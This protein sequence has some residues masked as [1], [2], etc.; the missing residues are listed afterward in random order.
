MRTR[1]LSVLGLLAIA[2]AGYSSD[3]DA[4]VHLIRLPVVE[5]TDIRFTHLSSPTDSSPGRV[6]HILQDDQGFIWLGTRD[7]LKRYDGYH[8]RE[9]RHD[10]TDPGSLSG[11]FIWALFKDRSGKL[12]VGSDSFL[13]RYD[14]ATDRF[15]R[16][17][18]DPGTAS[19]FKGP[20]YNVSQ[21]R[22]GIIWLS[23][24][25][26]LNRLDPATGQTVRYQ[27]EPNDPSSLSSNLI[28]STLEEKDGTFWVATTDGLDV[29]DRKTGKVTRHF[30]LLGQ[31]EPGR[32]S[33]FEDH[34]G[35]LW[36]IFSSGN[37]I[38]AVDRSANKIYQYS[39]NGQ[40]AHSGLEQL[41][42]IDSIFEDADGTLWLGTHGSGL[43]KL[44]KDR[45]EFVR[46]RNN[47]NDPTSLSADQVVAL[48][49]DRE[50]NMWAGT[51]EGGANRFS[52]KASPFRTYRHQPGN[53]NS[54]DGDIAQSVFEDSRGDLWVATQAA[55]N[56]MDRK[57]GRFIRYLNSGAPGSISNHSVMSI[58]EDRSGTLWFGT[59]GGGLNRLDEATGRFKAYRHNPADPQS[60]SQDIVTSLLVDRDGRLW[61][62]TVN[63][64]NAF[65]PATQRFRVYRAS[66]DGLNQYQVI[67]QD[68][69]GTLWLGT[70]TT[71]LQS[72]EPSTGRFT[73]YRYIPGSAG[74]LSND[75]VNAIYVDHFGIVWVGT[76]SGL[77]RFDPATHTFTAYNERDGLANNNVAGILQD[78]RGNLWL[79]TS[80]GLSRFDP[81]TK[82][83]TNYYVSDGLLKNEF[84]GLH[85]GWKSRSGEMLFN[86]HGGVVSFF[87]EKV[88]GN[89]YI[90]PVVFTDF[91]LFGKPVPIGNGS[92]LRRSIS[93]T[94]SLA[95][96][97]TQNVFSVEFSALSYTSPERNLYRYRLEGLETEW[98]DATGD[99]RLA[100]YTTLPPGD[101]TFRVQG[102]NNRGIW[103]E[104]GATLRIRVLP[105]WW[106]AWWFRV[107]VAVVVFGLLFGG[108]RWRVRDLQE[109]ERRFR[110]LAEHSPD[111]IVRFGRDLR[112]EYTNPAVSES[113]GLP[114]EKLL[115]M[116]SREMG[117]PRDQVGP[118]EAALRQV[119]QT[120]QPLVQ[121]F[122]FFLGQQGTRHFETRMVP[123]LEVD[124]SVR[125]VLAIS[126]DFSERK[127]ADAIL[128]E[129]EQQFR[130]L[131]E[132][133][134]DLIVRVSPE[135]RYEYV[136]RAAREY[137]GLP[138]EAY[139]Q[140]TPHEVP[141]GVRVDQVQ[142]WEAAMGRA[143]QTGQSLMGEFEFDGPVGLFRFESRFVLE[144]E[145]DNSIRSL[146][147]ISRDITERKRTETKLRESEQEFRTL[148][149][150]SPDLIVR[151]GP[152]LRRQ[153]TNPAVSEYSG[154]RQ[155]ELLHRTSR[156]LGGSEEQ[157]QSW[158]AALRTVFQT[159]RPLIQEIEFPSVFGLCQY[160]ARLVPELVDGSVRSVITISRDITSR[161]RAEARLR[162][163]EQQFR[164]LAEHSPDL[165]VR[166]GPDL[167]RQYTNPVVS[168]HSGL[169]Q[170][171][172]FQSTSRELGGPADQLRS[173]ETALRSVFQTG[174]PL[175]H[176]YEFPSVFGL[177]QYEARLVPELADGSVSSVLA[178][179]RDITE[180]KQAEAKL[181]E[182]EQEFRTLAE[183]APDLIM[184]IGP[185]LRY[186]YANP[187]MCEFL[188]LP[189]GAILG[190]TPR[191]HVLPEDQLLSWE[192]ALRS[193]FQTG[194]PIVQEFEFTG[195]KGPRNVESRVAPERDDGLVRSVLVILR[196]I[197]ERKRAEAILRESEQQFRII[198][199]D[200]PALLWMSSPTGENS[201]INRPLAAFLGIP[202]QS[203]LL[204][205]SYVVHPEDDARVRDKY[206]ECLARRSQ[207]SDEY[208]LR[209]FD[210]QYRWVLVRAI[211]R[212]SPTGEFLGYTGKIFDI[213][214]RKRAEEELRTA[215]DQLATELSE[216]IKAQ[217]EV[218]ALS[219]RLI[220]AQEQERA[221]I[222]RQLHDDIGQQIAAL[223][224]W[225]SNFKIQ[226]SEQQAG[227]AQNADL[228][229]KSLSQLAARVRQMSH[230]LHP[231]ILEHAG[232][233]VALKSYCVEF[234]SVSGVK[235][236][237]QVRGAF[238][239]VP[240]DAALCVYRVTQE[241]L[242]N[243]AKHAGVKEADVTL[244]RAGSD[245]RLTVS[246]RGV[247]FDPERA[248]KS[249][250]LGLVSMNER[251]RLVEGSLAVES[252]PS[253]GTTVRLEVP[254]SRAASA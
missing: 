32:M 80:N 54:L 109:R 67:A 24:L 219:H 243:V 180:R 205:G 225:L 249:G 35:V 61:A 213:S 167:R 94:N 92:P 241:A 185:D 207:L 184:R 45:K 13:D 57:T 163:S 28:K 148:A 127:R 236:S 93:L 17:G 42:G 63:G 145:A 252:S 121:E 104:Q 79:S 122:V 221:R 183:H 141:A 131:A 235:V 56:R 27:H 111:L 173:W 74:S 247:G 179:S 70:L 248:G 254:T 11:S 51:T 41:A 86:S 96:S 204:A 105:S 160:E 55:L 199:N 253:G 161:K 151:F 30:S 169:S 90:P 3:A 52:T 117:L 134:P 87:P 1:F 156:E 58:A 78:D 231:A 234:S 192:A 43:L 76:Q 194:E 218:I 135:L 103:N 108:Y 89:S 136:N 10:P 168:E 195:P 138:Q 196:D 95:L 251:V 40:A 206:L 71:G 9:Y 198:A 203:A 174:Q 25:H 137:S 126:R 37:G 33:L 84:Y 214:D 216:R 91:L 177:R 154:L 155:E 102:S 59:Y 202:Q 39:L 165:I 224:I 81:R 123:E 88:V 176:E 36:A 20:V 186:L 175:V 50:G 101:Y 150:H 240:P 226:V 77:N 143:F 75:Q 107:S 232:L 227:A 115:K 153:Y 230:E 220:T 120:G 21:D 190:K 18:V 128:R 125:S 119:F 53:P 182:S 124:G 132:N 149:E 46:Y 201:F 170:E 188:Q 130:T 97:H 144:R 238:Q 31:P 22:A 239:D 8:F 19:R 16:F 229:H 6:S 15:T 98:N 38:A 181:R 44:G 82:R 110:T 112:H 164:T 146:L 172:L 242:Q 191:D 2:S 65:D 14:F 29:F 193:V 244:I 245:V 152:D 12:W 113:T 129:S 7:G 162:E 212:T 228:L 223:S 159:G 72:L 246:D 66:G 116:S 118:W 139:L 62:G 68:A 157:L 200:T 85:A 222:A 114:Q 210:G 217:Q 147:V 166:F 171:E 215:N 106:S 83:F 64:L 209:R 187:V 4:S 178:I 47:P 26:G 208:R 73:V 23:T 100:T 34:A 140:K 69:Q 233:A 211:P 189:L 158:E 133:A 5:G 99:H 60:I 48:L 250:G 197:T 142:I 49:E 237:I